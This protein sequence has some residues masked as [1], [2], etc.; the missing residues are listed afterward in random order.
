[1]LCK[2]RRDEL[3][4][5][6]ICGWCWNDFDDTCM[7]CRRSI[8]LDLY[9]ECFKLRVLYRPCSRKFNGILNDI[10]FRIYNFIYVYSSTKSKNLKILYHNFVYLSSKKF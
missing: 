3:N 9:E 8:R 7:L 5:A 1:M 4:Q 2:E 6:T 10:G